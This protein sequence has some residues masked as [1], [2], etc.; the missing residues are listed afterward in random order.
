MR[1]LLLTLALT[2]LAGS[3]AAQKFDY[4]L[5]TLSW[6][7]EFC[8]ENPSNHTPECAPGAKG[9]FVVHGLWPSTNTG[10]GP[11][12]CPGDPFTASAVPAGLDA[13]M[14]SQIF[15]H[16]WVTHGVCSPMNEHDYLARIASLYHGLVIPVTNSGADQQISP[17][18]LR[19]KFA[20]ANPGSKTGSFAIQDNG[21]YLVA[22]KKCLGRSFEPISCPKPGDTSASPITLRAK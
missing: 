3:A 6:S 4:Y 21:K 11:Q 16:E 5:F 19:Q 20:S 12:N 8:H 1:A 7:P 22:V 14:P 15:R 13:I 17:A 9:G 2:V 18:A 10:T